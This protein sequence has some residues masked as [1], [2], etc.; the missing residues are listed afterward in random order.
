[1]RSW[2]GEDKLR[3]GDI[4]PII[5]PQKGERLYQVLIIEMERK[6]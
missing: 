5:Q 3:V 2:K 6:T 1:M 4:V